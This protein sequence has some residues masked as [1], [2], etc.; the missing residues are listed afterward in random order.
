MFKAIYRWF[1]VLLC[2][3]FKIFDY[4]GRVV[5]WHDNGGVY[6]AFRCSTCGYIDKELINHFEDPLKDIPIKTKDEQQ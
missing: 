3:R 1:H 5:S 6:I 2:H 4:S